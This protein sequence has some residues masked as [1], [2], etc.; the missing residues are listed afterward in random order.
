MER[1]TR[2]TPASAAAIETICTSS[3]TVTVLPLTGLVIVMLGAPSPVV[4]PQASPA[5]TRK[6]TGT[7][8]IRRFL[9]LNILHLL[10]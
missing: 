2:A 3:P 8:A 5:S 9:C 4:G 10:D 6:T 1:S 7:T